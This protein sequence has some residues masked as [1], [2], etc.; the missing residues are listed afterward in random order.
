MEA[1]SGRPLAQSNPQDANLLVVLDHFESDSKRRNEQHASPRIPRFSDLMWDETEKSVDL[2]GCP[3][4]GHPV[5]GIDPRGR[6]LPL[7]RRLPEDGVIH[8]QPSRFLI[9]ARVRP[10]VSCRTRSSSSSDTSV[11]AQ[12]Y[13]A[14]VYE[15][16]GTEGTK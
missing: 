1:A 9:S 6:E 8:D 11:L 14:R 15:S 5:D 12:S 16:E 4:H 10:P 2:V 3:R 13:T 7:G